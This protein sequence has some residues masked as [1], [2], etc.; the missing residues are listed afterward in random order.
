MKLGEPEYLGHGH[1]TREQ[2]RWPRPGDV[3]SGSRTL[4][5]C[6]IIADAGVGD[7]AH[8]WPEFF[9]PGVHTLPRDDTAPPTEEVGHIPPPL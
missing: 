9:T 1:T 7:A 5:C 6:P 2:Q 4:E 8:Q 3:A